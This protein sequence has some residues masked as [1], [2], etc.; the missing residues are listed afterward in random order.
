MTRIQALGEVALQEFG[1]KPSTIRPLVHAENTTFYVEAAE[2]RF[3]L[4]VGRPG[5]QTR[6]RTE[7]EISFLSALSEA[8]FRVPKPWE[9]R[10]VTVSHPQTPE[11]RNCVL[12]GWRDGEFADK[13]YSPEQAFRVGQ[14]MAGLHE[15]SSTW[16]PPEGFDRMTVLRTPEIWSRGATIEQVGADD[17]RLIIEVLELCHREFGR[18]PRD[19]EH[20]GL[21]HSDLHHGNVLFEGDHLNVI[22]F[23]DTVWGFWGCDF[24]AALAFSFGLDTFETLKRRMYEGYSSVR[25]LP[26][27]TQELFNLFLVF[28][29]GSLANWV[30][31]RDDNPR[32]RVTGHR[33][34]TSL[35]ESIRRICSATPL[36][37]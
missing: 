28:R 30:M 12:L 19:I 11:A 6:A 21:I 10:V 14:A 34:A 20:W 29:L 36:L 4:R 26:P 7:S 18:L 1:V 35:C 15:F 16:R 23:D 22:D 31:T 5:Y 32:F 2:G 37:S 33:W 24:A 13:S 8:E 17:A 3:N 9:A 27:D 25:P